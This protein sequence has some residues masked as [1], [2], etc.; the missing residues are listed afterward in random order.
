MQTTRLP[1]TKVAP[2]LLLVEPDTLDSSERAAQLCRALFNV[3]RADT[4][5]HVHLLRGVP[6]ISVAVLSDTIGFVALRA[7]AELVRRQWPKARILILGK[8]PSLFDD[9]LYDEALLHT[10]SDAALVAMIE[11][12]SVDPWNQRGGS[13]SAWIDRVSVSPRLQKSGAVQES[14][15]TKAPKPPRTPEYPKDWPA[16]EQFRQAMR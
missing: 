12:V 13:S 9:H 16:S 11:Q 14:D 8:A 3:T 2:S 1:S 7:S 15:P 6:D 5:Q 4:P 10:S